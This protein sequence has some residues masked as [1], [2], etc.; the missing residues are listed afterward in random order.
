M[1]SIA[2]TLSDLL[3]E[4]Y[5]VAEKQLLHPQTKI[6]GSCTSIRCMRFN[7]ASPRL[8]YG[9]QLQRTRGLDSFV[10]GGIE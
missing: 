1:Q 2:T 4:F 3:G 6:W 9:C 7:L 5:C 8:D 10:I